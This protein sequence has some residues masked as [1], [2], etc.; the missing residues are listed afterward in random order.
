MKTCPCPCGCKVSANTLEE[1]EIIFGW[2]DKITQSYCKKC[3]VPHK[4]IQNAE[5]TNQIF[6]IILEGIKRDYQFNIDYLS[7]LPRYNES[8]KRLTHVMKNKLTKEYLL[9]KNNNFICHFLQLLDKKDPYIEEEQFLKLFEIYNFRT[10]KPEAESFFNF[11]ISSESKEINLEQELNPNKQIFVILKIYQTITETYVKILSTKLKNSSA[12]IVSF[13]NDIH[14]N[15]IENNDKICI[16]NRD[17]IKFLLK[18]RNGEI[19]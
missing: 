15:F 3:R 12:I 5:K 18:Y 7:K 10:K 19:K 17:M 1:I 14:Q 11:V 2:R 4:G 16:L 13:V 9:T 8:G 6:D